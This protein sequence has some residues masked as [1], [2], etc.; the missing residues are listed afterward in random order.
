[1]PKTFKANNELAL[2]QADSR[3]IY[4]RLAA[5]PWVERLAKLGYAAKGF[6]YLIGGGTALLAAMGIGGRVRGMRGAL[7]LIVTYPFGRVAIALIAAGL[8]GFVLRRF[9][10]IFAAP[11]VGVP[12]KKITRFMRRTGYFFSGLAHIGVA[13]VALRLMLGLRMLKSDGGTVSPR[14]WLS[15]LLT[16]KPFNGWLTLLVGFGVVGFALFHFY[17]AVSRR[18]TIDLQLE[19]LSRRA[20]VTM[21]ICGSAGYAG[22]GLAFLITGAFLVYAGWFVE[23]VEARSYSDILRVIEAQALGW[24]VLILVAAGLFAYGLYLLLAARYLRLVAAW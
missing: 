18:F 20:E 19:R 21:F 15:L 17:M 7:K 23:E 6:L 2:E 12:P 11:T 16:Q 13:L 24:W 5:N 9:V 1:M 22:R 3:R 14:D 8:C 4:E 10:Q